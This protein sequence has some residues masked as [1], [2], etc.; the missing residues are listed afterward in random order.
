MKKI[1]AN[2]FVETVYPG[3]NVG[4]IVTEVGAV[5]VDTPM[6][7]GEAQRWMARIRSLG[8]ELARFVIYTSGQRDRILGTQHLIC[9][10]EAPCAPSPLPVQEFSHPVR[11]PLGRRERQKPSELPQ[12]V[13]KGAVV[14]QSRTWE[15]VKEHRTESFKQSMVDLFGDRDPDMVNLEVVLPQIT[16]DERLTLY[17]GECTVMVLEAAQGAAWVWL[18]EHRVL[19]AGDTVVVGT[20]PQLAIIDM[21]A[22]LAALERLRHDPQFQDVTIVPGRGPVCDALATRPLTEYLQL[23]CNKTRQVY[24]AGRPKADLNAVAAEL[25]PLYPVVD[26]QRE[27]VQ[28]QI[29]VGLDELYDSFKAADAAVA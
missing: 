25:L 15:Q 11:P 7:P 8:A 19:F 13:T 9:D 24:R 3:V 12:A 4:C 14:A 29:K 17:A 16:F 18:P 22:W 5:C 26:G 27:R 23:A 20:H 21:D 2:I 28:R 1:G 10:P 6:L